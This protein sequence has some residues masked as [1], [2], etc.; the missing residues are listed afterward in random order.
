MTFAHARRNANLMALTAAL[1]WSMSFVCIREVLDQ[2]KTAS[3]MPWEAALAL[4]QSR[5]LLT[6]VAFVPNVVA[7]RKWIGTLNRRDWMLV[8]IILLTSSFGYHLPLNLGAQHLPSGFVSLL[9]ALSPIFAALLA[10]VILGEKLGIARLTA[11][12]LGFLGIGICLVAQKRFRFD[13]GFLGWNGVLGPVCVMLAAMDGAFFAVIGR[14]VRKEIPAGL[15]LGIAMIGTVLFALPLWNSTILHLLTQLNARGWLAIL[16]LAI[17]CTHTASLL[18]YGALKTLDAVE[19]TI[20]LNATTLFAL[21]WGALIFHEK[22]RP[23][24][25]VGALCIMAAVFLATRNQKKE[26]DPPPSIS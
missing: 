6:A 23:L 10:R 25:L 17:V 19:V 16:Y 5:M 21:L 9:I 20:Y 13:I 7:E 12:L 11:V 8:G 3:T 4:F 18:W 14:S 15:K 26:M 1:F 2:L 24:Y 22:I